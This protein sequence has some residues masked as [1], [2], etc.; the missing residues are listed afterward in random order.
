MP[1]HPALFRFDTYPAAALRVALGAN[2]GE[3]IGPGDAAVPGDSYR[4]AP[5][6]AALRLAISDD[7][8]HGPCVASGSAVGAPGTPI[9]ILAC[10]MFMDPGGRPVEALLL[11]IGA[12]RR[13]LPL[14]AFRT[15]T[16]YELLDCDTASAPSRFAD[17]ASVSF[18]AGT[19]LAMA[20][21]RQVPV[22]E[23][24]AGDMLLTRYNGPCPIRRIGHRTR[25]ATGTA[26]PVRITAGTLNAARD[27]RLSP[28][29]RLF[30]WQRRDAL[31]AGRAEVLVR[32]G[33]LV[34]GT[35]VLREE[36][37]HFDSCQI[38][39]DG[40]E[41]IFAEGIA[42]E[43]MLV[44]GPAPEDIDLGPVRAEQLHASDLEIDET[45]LGPDAADRLARA[46]RGEPD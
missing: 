29:H 32:A 12:E 38:L 5:R 34:N 24:Q 2:E 41:I 33:L 46:S 27:L 28:Q 1:R 3:P 42:V 16:D 44:A 11:D 20:D 17:V 23:L 26:A 6:A 39:F 45:A 31:G 14:A 8:E 15:D 40:H 19:N 21:G 35:T 10:A 4:L 25:R 13:I 30:V 7:P 18:Y 43:S 9:A 36:G 37:G 22:E